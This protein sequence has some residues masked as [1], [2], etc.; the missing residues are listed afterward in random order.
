MSTNNRKRKGVDNDDEQAVKDE[1]ADDE[2]TKR[3]RQSAAYYGFL[4]DKSPGDG[5]G[6]GSTRSE[7]TYTF[8]KRVLEH[9]QSLH[10]H[11]NI[12]YNYRIDPD[13]NEWPTEMKSIRLVIPRSFPITPEEGSWLLVSTASDSLSNCLPTI[14]PLTHPRPTPDQS[15]LIH[16]T[17]YPLTLYP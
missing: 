12:P 17:W 8:H 9:Y 15:A 3:T 11:L 13:T 6:G 1:D 2:S 14:I 7:L 5:S 10:G 16:L 4:D